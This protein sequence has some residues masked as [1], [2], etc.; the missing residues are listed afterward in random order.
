MS[1]LSGMWEGRDFD[2][3]LC[4]MCCVASKSSVELCTRCQEELGIKDQIEKLKTENEEMK[5]IFHLFIKE[6]EK[7]KVENEEMKSILLELGSTTH[8]NERLHE[9]YRKQLEG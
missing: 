9:S 2:C 5:S 3:L 4:G 8:R 1:V 6:I 7:L